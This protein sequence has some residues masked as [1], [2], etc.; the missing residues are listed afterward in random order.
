MTSLKQIKH[1]QIQTLTDAYINTRSELIDIAS[2]QNI[3]YQDLSF[4]LEQ[5]QDKYRSSIDKLKA[6]YKDCE[7]SLAAIE[8]I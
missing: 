8:V 6:T 3:S 1:Y 2:Q 4:A 5:L 7:T